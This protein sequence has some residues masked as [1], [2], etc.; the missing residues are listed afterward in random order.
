MASVYYSVW[1]SVLSSTATACTA[2]SVEGGLHLW[3]STV[4]GGSICGVQ[5]HGY[6]RSGSTYPACLVIRIHGTAQGVK[7]STQWPQSRGT[8]GIWVNDL[9]MEEFQDLR[10]QSTQLNQHAKCDPRLLRGKVVQEYVLPPMPAL[11]KPWLIVVMTCLL[12]VGGWSPPLRQ[13][14]TDVAAGT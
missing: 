1:S 6:S 11:S 14:P 5:L 3:C 7:P 4:D 2:V 10:V 9:T 12:V 8:A 13:S